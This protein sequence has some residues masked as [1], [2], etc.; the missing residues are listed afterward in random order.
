MEAGLKSVLPEKSN[1]HPACVICSLLS[2]VLIINDSLPQIVVVVVVVV[3]VVVVVASS[4]RK[5]CT[6][7]SVSTPRTP[8]KAFL[9]YECKFKHAA[10]AV[11]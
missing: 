2:N 11:I 4:F 3:D 10:P 5:H 9:S 6:R 8:P 7:L 1:I